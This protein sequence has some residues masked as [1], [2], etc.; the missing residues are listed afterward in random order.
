M[1]NK[2][3]PWLGVMVAVML[4]MMTLPAFA[5]GEASEGPSMYGTFW[6]LVPPWWPSFWL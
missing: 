4:A 2:K 3:L 1:R 6:A 5:A